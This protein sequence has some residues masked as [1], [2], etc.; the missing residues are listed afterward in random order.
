RFGCGVVVQR[1]LQLSALR[2]LGRGHRKPAK[3]AL[4]EIGLLGKAQHFGIEA[5]G[6]LLVVDVHTGQLYFHLVSPVSSSRFGPRR[7]SPCLPFR[8]CCPLHGP[9]HGWIHAVEMAFESVYV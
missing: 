7:L 2:L 8:W 3:W 4:A 1:Q 9:I 6:F 5:Q